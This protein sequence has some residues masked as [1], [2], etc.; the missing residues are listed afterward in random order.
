MDSILY[1][2][3]DT[4][5]GTLDSL[6][7]SELS[8]STERGRSSQPAPWPIPAAWDRLTGLGAVDFVDSVED[9]KRAP[10]SYVASEAARYSDDP[11][12]PQDRPSPQH[13]P[14]ALRP[15]S[16]SAPNSA[17]PSTRTGSGGQVSVKAE[18]PPI[19]TSSFSRWTGLLQSQYPLPIRMVT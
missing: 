18:P 10:S 12:K 5:T 8:M 11:P 15:G 3:G 9:D 7:C 16:S 6:D 14:V 19:V 4:G 1:S 17:R 2:I 13:A